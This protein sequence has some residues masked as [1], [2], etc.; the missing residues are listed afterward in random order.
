MKKRGTAKPHTDVTLS[1]LDMAERAFKQRD[2]LHGALR[3]LVAKVDECTEASI[4]IF[5]IAA[6]HGC[7]Y[8]GPNYKTEMDEAR[9]VLATLS[10]T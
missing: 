5:R 1:A 8:S 10:P 6:I 7:A 9:A 4:G 2:A 3:S